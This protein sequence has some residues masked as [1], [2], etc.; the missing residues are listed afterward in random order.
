MW[1]EV[2]SGVVFL[3]A[4]AIA[5]PAQAPQPLAFAIREDNDYFN[6]WQRR[7]DR[8]D[9][10]YTQG[11]QLSIAWSRRPLLRMP[12]ILDGSACARDG[13][14]RVRCVRLDAAIGQQM[15]TPDV[16][17]PQLLPGQRPYAGWLYV[18]VGE[19]SESVRDFDRLDATV[20]VTG[21]PSLAESTQGVWHEWFGFRRPLG[22]SGQLPFETDFAVTWTHARELLPNGSR[23]ASV[24]HLAP[25]GA[26]ELGTLRTALD[27]GARI[28]IGFHPPATWPG[29]RQPAGGGRFGVYLTAAAGGSGVVRNLFLD[30][31]TFRPSGLVR[32]NFLVGSAS[33]GIGISAGRVRLEA[34]AVTMSREY[35]TQ[36]APHTYTSLS[37][38]V[39]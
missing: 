2:V 10:E 14:P 27:L 24:A 38:R 9:D 17:S 30:G 4:G 12:G 18:A 23:G 5:A 6:L 36:P 13:D 20:G 31:D 11:L 35:P 22:W 29:D 28:A 25:Y 37:V 21:P 19:T 8:P 26:V 39:W 33:L 15:Y 3:A 7:R 32:K 16:D 1:Q 34:T